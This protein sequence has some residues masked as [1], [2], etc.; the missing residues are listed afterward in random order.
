[1][2]DQK[3]G[4]LTA[5]KDDLRRDVVLAFATADDVDTVEIPGTASIQLTEGQS[6]VLVVMAASGAK[7]PDA[8]AFKL[9]KFDEA[10]APAAADI[11]PVLSRLKL[12]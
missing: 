11:E 9:L 5:T 6:R 7:E 8:A 12:N 4:L 10:W 2:P 3:C 1:M